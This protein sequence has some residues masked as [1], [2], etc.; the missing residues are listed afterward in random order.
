MTGQ[1]KGKVGL[2]VLER[3]E[4]KEEEG[5]TRIQRRERKTEEEEVEGRWS[6]TTWPGEATSSKGSHSWKIE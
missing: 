3:E 6:R 4:E 5:E 1:W 2:E